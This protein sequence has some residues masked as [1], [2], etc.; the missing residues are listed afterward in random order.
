[1]RLYVLSK[2][3]RSCQDGLLKPYCS[4]ASLPLAAYQYKVSILLPVTDNMLFS[5][6]GK[7]EYFS[8]KTCTG[9]E[10]TYFCD[11]QPTYRVR[12]MTLCSLW[13]PNYLAVH[14]YLT[15]SK[16]KKKCLVSGYI[17]KINFFFN[18][19][20]FNFQMYKVLQTL[21]LHSILL[22][23]LS[24]FNMDA[25]LC[26]KQLT[27]DYII[28]ISIFAFIYMNCAGKMVRIARGRLGHTVG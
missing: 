16:A 12:F 20:F 11:Y 23:N 13:P 7:R 25:V 4:W 26:R 17:P 1:M 2:Q 5:N 14:F 6:Q 21:F 8:I 24:L 22:T 3:L 19:V 27:P 10:A 28:S 15:V 9:C 18:K